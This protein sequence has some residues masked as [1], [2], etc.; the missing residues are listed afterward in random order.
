MERF[1]GIFYC[2]FTVKN[3]VAVESEV[4]K[5][6]FFGLHKQGRQTLDIRRQA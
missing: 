5:K 6:E 3:R 4:S 1:K 2:S